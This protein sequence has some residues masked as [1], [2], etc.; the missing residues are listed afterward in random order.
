MFTQAVNNAPVVTERTLAQLK[1]GPSVAGGAAVSA[2][3]SALE[4]G[5]IAAIA[6]A[7]LGPE[8]MLAAGIEAA[9]AAAPSAA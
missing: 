2:A 5:V 8:A 4:A 1:N 3:E 9:I 7:P 6:A